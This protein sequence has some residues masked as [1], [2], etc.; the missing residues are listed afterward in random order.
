[1]LKRTL[2]GL[3]LLGVTTLANAAPPTFPPTPLPVGNDGFLYVTIAGDASSELQPRFCPANARYSDGLL[4]HST[5]E[6]TQGNPV[7]AVTAQTVLDQTFGAGKAF[8][9]G[10]TPSSIVHSI[11]YYRIRKEK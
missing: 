5:C 1:M 2:T 4:R 8:A 6:D 3:A 7:Q 10:I 11:V 9:V